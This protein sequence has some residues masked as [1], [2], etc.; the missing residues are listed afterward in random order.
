MNGFDLS[1][2]SGIFVGSTEYSAIYK[3]S[4]LIWE[5]EDYY[6]SQY[7]T[8]ESLEDDNVITWKMNSST[9]PEKTIEYSTDKITWTSATSTTSGTTLA[10]LDTDEKLYLRGNNTQ[11]C[12]GNGNQ[13]MFTSTKKF[14]LSGNIMSLINSS[15]FSN[16][17]SLA[18]LGQHTFRTMFQGTKVVDASRLQLPA[19]TLINGCYNA[20]F[21]DCGYLYNAPKLPA[22]TLGN[23]CYMQLFD[24][25]SNLTVAP[26]LPATT[27]KSQCYQ[28]MFSKCNKITI[29]PAL[30]A[31]T[32]AN[33]CYMGMFYNCTNITTAPELP[34]TKLSQ[35]CYKN[36][37]YN[38]S[39]LNYIK[40]LATNIS[41]TDCLKNWVYG[42]SASGTFIKDASMT[43]LTTGIHG[44]PDGWTVQDAA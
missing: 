24:S 41:A 37:F 4:S 2:I 34:A 3:G 10:T 28:S 33:Y 38:C 18:N 25:C 26:E 29:A 31:T 36:M 39:K 44:I 30:P 19:T 17:T 12:I 35:E 6:K 23:H 13:N 27:M 15:S 40:M 14:N 22:T 8:I 16:L 42:V 5:N 7:L 43:S 1:T 20:M 9:T 11:Y 32:L 21:Q